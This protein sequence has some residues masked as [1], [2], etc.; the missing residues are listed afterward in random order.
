[1]DERLVCRVWAS[2]KARDCCG[3]FPRTRNRTWRCCTT[4]CRD[5]PCLVQEQTPMKRAV[6][7]VLLLFLSLSAAA[8]Q[9]TVL[10]RLF[11]QHPP[12]E[13]RVTPEGASFRTCE[14][15]LATR[16]SGP[17][18]ITA[19]ASSVSAGSVSSSQVLLK[20]R[21]HISR[22]G[23]SPFAI[24][25]ELRIQAH[26]DLLL[27][28]LTMPLEQYVTAVL[29]GESANFKSDEAL[30]AMAVSARTYA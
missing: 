11:W 8:Q 21:A 2:R 10:V 22:N 20:G 17:L 14:N 4:G 19:K 13:I 26:D 30:K 24:E 6:C 16:L 27:L 9:R 12:T 3:R 25:N 1:M 28:T 23:F 29:Q 15:C 5:I 7:T 18:E